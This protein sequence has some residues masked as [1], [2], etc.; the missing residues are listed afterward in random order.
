MS[1]RDCDSAD[2]HETRACSNFRIEPFIK[3][4]ENLTYG[5]D[6]DRGYK[7]TDGRTDVLC[8]RH[9]SSYFLNNA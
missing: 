9:I 7:G 1:F 5:L 2:F 4:H 3:F 8:I 6:D